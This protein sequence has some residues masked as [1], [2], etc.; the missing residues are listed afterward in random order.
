MKQVWKCDHCSQTNIDP[1]IIKEHEIK[2][3]FNEHNKYCNTCDHHIWEGYG[4][5]G[6]YECH[7]GKDY[8]T[9]EDDGNCPDW[10][11]DDWT[12]EQRQIRENKITRIL[13]Q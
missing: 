4:S 2:C 6:W 7:I 1:N 13:N 3:S 12:E 9:Y 10:K 8:Q 5:D 11:N